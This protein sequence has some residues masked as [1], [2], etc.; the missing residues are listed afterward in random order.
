MTTFYRYRTIQ[1]DRWD[2]IAQ[3]FYADPKDYVGIMRVNP[4]FAGELYLPAGQDINVPVKEPVELKQKI[5]PP[6][7]R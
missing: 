4:D 7:L 1:G 6:W 3:E 5:T 2:T